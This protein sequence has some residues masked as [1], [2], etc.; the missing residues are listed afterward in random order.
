MTLIDP[1]WLSSS[2]RG[3]APLGFCRGIVG[4]GAI[5]NADGRGLML[6]TAE[7]TERPPRIS[8]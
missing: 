8:L 3:P 1:D 7:R 4:S 5:F 6:R 2:A